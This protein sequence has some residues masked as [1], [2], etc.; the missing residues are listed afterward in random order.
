MTNAY[1]ELVAA[2]ERGELLQ[3]NKKNAMGTLLSEEQQLI[4]DHCLNLTPPAHDRRVQGLI[5]GNDQA[6]A[7]HAKI[8]AALAPL[9]AWPCDLCPEALSEQTVRRLRRL[10]ESDVGSEPAATTP[11]RLPLRHRL[12]NAAGVLT[13]AAVV[14]FAVGILL[15]VSGHLRFR[16]GCALCAAQSNGLYKGIDAYAADF[17]GM[18]PMVAQATGAFW[19]RIGHRGQESHSNTRNLFLLGKHHYVDSLL[20]FI[21]CGREREDAPRLDL[22]KRPEAEDF[23]SR[24]AV[25]YSYRV[26]GGQPVK[27]TSLGAQPLLADM[28][29][30]FERLPSDPLAL[31]D[32]RLKEGWQGHHSINHGRRGQNV[33]FA[34]GH[35]RFERGRCWGRHQDDM[36]T[37]RDTVVYHGSERPADTSDAF[38]GP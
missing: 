4:L 31:L 13:A 33:C 24:D 8:Q 14:I 29:P 25:T 30:H 21:C 28:N 12:S 10:V 26:F 34:D 23:P 5:R 16:H 7:T 1:N 35:V 11:I 36:Y 32:V 19:H 15:P 3:K 27:L 9:A 6:A 2:R 37:I 22:A 20:D 38:L 18:L 17:N